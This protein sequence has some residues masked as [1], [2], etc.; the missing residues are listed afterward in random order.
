MAGLPVPTD[1]PFAGPWQLSGWTGCQGTC[2]LW[3]WAYVL[4][5]LLFGEGGRDGDTPSPEP[6]AR[7]WRLWWELGCLQ[8]QRCEVSAVLMP[9]LSSPDAER[10]DSTTSLG[11]AALDFRSLSSACT[12]SRCLPAAPS[13]T[14]TGIPPGTHSLSCAEMTHSSAFMKGW[15]MQPIPWGAQLRQ[16]RAPPAA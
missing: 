15:Q 10:V 7:R 8:R 3:P 5:A 11:K 14:V 4:E 16:T 2:T 9:F 12:G 13:L 6:L 1:A